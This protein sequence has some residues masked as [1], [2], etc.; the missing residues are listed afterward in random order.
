MRRGRKRK[1]AATAQRRRVKRNSPDDAVGALSKLLGDGVALIDD[2]VLVE[3]LED[4]PSLEVGH[5]E[6][7]CAGRFG[8]VREL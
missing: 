4:L 5:G 2:K 6:R 8:G 1:R 3:D 7:V